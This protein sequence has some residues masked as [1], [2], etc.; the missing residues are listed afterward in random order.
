MKLYQVSSTQF[1]GTDQSELTLRS[2]WQKV[3][4]YV[5]ALDEEEASLVFH[6]IHELDL[7]E[8]YDVEEIADLGVTILAGILDPTAGIYH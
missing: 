7:P 2:A 6:Q 8:F 4:L 3:E 1:C 5:N